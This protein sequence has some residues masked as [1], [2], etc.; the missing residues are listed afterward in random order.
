MDDLSALHRLTG[1][2]GSAP[3]AWSDPVAR[4]IARTLG[5][6]KAH[7]DQGF[8]A[9][10]LLHPSAQVRQ[11]AAT[12][13]GAAQAATASDQPAPPSITLE[14]ALGRLDQP[15]LP[16]KVVLALLTAD[17]GTV[18]SSLQAQTVTG[19][20]REQSNAAAI[21]RLMEAQPSLPELLRYEKL[22]PAH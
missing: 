21:L 13:L 6:T 17:Q 12:T 11:L 10:L 2:A 9:R 19:T 20:P 4:D 14:D 1:G 3:A 16:R 7:G 15:R 22:R 5:L 8:W 18:R